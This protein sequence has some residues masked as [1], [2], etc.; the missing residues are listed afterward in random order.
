MTT[1]K[2]KQEDANVRI[3][4][5]DRKRFRIAALNK[6]VSLKDFMHTLAMKV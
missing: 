3:Y 4:K 2:K 1:K 6:S 5:E